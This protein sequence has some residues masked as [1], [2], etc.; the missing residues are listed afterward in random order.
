MALGG[1]HVAATVGGRHAQHTSAAIAIKGVT[2]TV[3]RDGGAETAGAP[4]DPE[5]PP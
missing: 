4:R 1:S 5:R 3:Y 2:P